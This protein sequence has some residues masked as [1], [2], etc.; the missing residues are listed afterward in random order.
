M[1][2]NAY[3]LLL[4]L[5]LLSASVW[6]SRQA[7]HSI[8]GMLLETSGEKCTRQVI[9]GCTDGGGY[10]DVDRDACHGGQRADLLSHLTEAALPSLNRW[11]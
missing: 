4:L 5:F 1:V 9:T 3:L 8:A 10:V 11:R 2:N 6:V 7:N